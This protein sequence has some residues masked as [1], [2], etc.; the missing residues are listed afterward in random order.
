MLANISRDARGRRGRSP[1]QHQGRQCVTL[2]GKA[3]AELVS[4]RPP[5]TIGKAS[6]A[7]IIGA[8][9]SDEG[10]NISLGAEQYKAA[11]VSQETIAMGGTPMPQTRSPI[12]DRLKTA[13]RAQYDAIVSEPL[14]ERWVDLIKRLN[15]QERV[16]RE[17]CKAKQRYLSQGG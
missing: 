2:T 5:R 14:P 9:K 7:A 8:R 15:E 3:L 13:F 11:A 10:S 12:V 4:S 1:D 6:V 17:T 16:Q